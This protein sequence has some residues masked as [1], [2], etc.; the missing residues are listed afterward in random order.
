MALDDSFLDVFLLSIR[1]TRTG[2]N[3][4]D[5]T[6]LRA[7]FRLEDVDGVVVGVGWGGGGG[8]GGGESTVACPV[9]CCRRAWVLL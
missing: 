1:A 3:A 9:S 7:F 2:P 4:T 5:A 6:K 8:G